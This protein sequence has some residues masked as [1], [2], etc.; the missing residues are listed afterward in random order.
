MNK[1]ELKRVWKGGKKA[2]P[3]YIISTIVLFLFGIV[4]IGG[5]S[6]LWYVKDNVDFTQSVEA[7]ITDVRMHSSGTDGL[8][9]YS[10]FYEYTS[11]DGTYYC[12][13][14]G[15]YN[16]REAATATLN[17]GDK[18]PIY[19]DGKGTSVPSDVY[20]NTPNVWVLIVGIIF[21]VAGLAVFSILVIPHKWK[22]E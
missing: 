2:I 6:E 19:I 13:D 1:S 21:L 22:H 17:I 18:V 12:G 7:T 14:I 4:F 10:L 16:S 11:Q 8:Y 9:S 5:Y 3:F 15:Y 20:R